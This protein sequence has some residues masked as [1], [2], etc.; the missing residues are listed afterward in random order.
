M[1]P[2]GIRKTGLSSKWLPETL[3][4][5]KEPV[6]MANPYQM[7]R[8]KKSNTPQLMMPLLEGI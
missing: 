7:E 5:R 2:F 4:Q 3:T 1:P 8:E 6:I